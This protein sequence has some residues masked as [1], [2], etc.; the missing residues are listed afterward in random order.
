M[1]GADSIRGQLTAMAHS[2]TPRGP[3]SAGYWYSAEHAI[4]FAHRRLA[5]VDLSDAGHQ[6][7]I[8]PSQ[9]YVITFNG[10]IYNH[11]DLREQLESGG[12]GQTNWQGHSD[13]ETLIA[14]IEAWG[15][16]KTLSKSIGMFAFALW[17]RQKKEVYIARDRIGEKPLYYGCQ[18]GVFLFGSEL[19]ALT[20]HPAFKGEVDRNAI[21]LLL[22]HN[23]IPTPMQFIRI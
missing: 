13:T 22:R 4:A 15:L 3:D 17:D 12:L 6:P 20:A 11:T 7:M 21:T 1:D 16:E 10:E 9:R 19:K 18:Q 2:L 14:G 8:S 5:I 23:Y